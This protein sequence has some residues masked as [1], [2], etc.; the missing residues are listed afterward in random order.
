VV[1]TSTLLIDAPVETATQQGGN[2]RKRTTLSFTE[3]DN[4]KVG[5]GGEDEKARC[6]STNLSI[7]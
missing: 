3:A 6:S 5:R 1:K 7:C 4:D 2:E